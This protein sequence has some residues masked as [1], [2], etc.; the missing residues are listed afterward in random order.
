MASLLSK[1]NTRRQTLTAKAIES[2]LGM[3]NEED[4]VGVV[5]HDEWHE[6]IIG[7]VAS[8]LV[9][10][11]KKPMVVISRRETVS[12]GSARSIAGFNIVDAIRFSSE[13]LID[14]GGHPMAAGFSIRTEH[15]EAF[16]KKIKD[17][18][19]ER[20]TDDLLVQNISVECELEKE[21]IN[22]ETLKIIEMFAP[23]PL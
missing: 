13:Y 9:E 19:R 8:R 18:G 6:G 10:N 14:G 3:V 23:F 15:I 17:F 11:Y 1:T 21:D 16:S 22:S 7:L 20:I 5:V 2:A 4:A 12:K